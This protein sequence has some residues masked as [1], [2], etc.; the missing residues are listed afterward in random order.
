MKWSSVKNI[1]LGMLIVMNVFV[2]CAVLVQRL[3]TENIPPVVISAATET[4]ERG[5]I[6]CDGS[7]LPDKYITAQLPGV[8]FFTP[9]ELSRMFFGSQLAFQTNGTALIA[10]SGDAEL[11][12]DGETFTYKSGKDSAEADEKQLR[13][14]LRQLG[15]SL[16]GAQY[17]EKYNLFC[18][19]Y[20]GNPLFGMYIRAELDSDGEISSIEACWPELSPS[21]NL[22]TGVN[23]ISH[24][25]DISDAFPGGGT[26]SRVR[27]GY[28]LSRHRGTEVYELQ[29]AW[30]VTL[31]DGRSRIFRSANN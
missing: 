12:V 19:Y 13:R 2:I 16:R 29:P 10:H 4:L 21:G 1:I 24:L 7:L 20:D 26:V 8:S 14:A 31:E 25:P 23:I 3:S 9:T 28:S 18:C 5:G 30:R 15:F 27:F 17:S 22:E 11:I 6:I